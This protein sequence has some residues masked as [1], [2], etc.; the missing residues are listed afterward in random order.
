MKK[1]KKVKLTAA[2]KKVVVQNCGG[3]P[4]IKENFT[5]ARKA[6]TAGWAIN[7]EGKLYLTSQATAKLVELAKFVELAKPDE[8]PLPWY[9]ANVKTLK[10]IDVY[11]MGVSG[12]T[13]SFT[14][15]NLIIWW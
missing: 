3:I 4:I 12:F 13:M 9:K 8:K 6:V 11:A 2:Q 5:Q 15:M 1:T 10:P 7:I 14:L